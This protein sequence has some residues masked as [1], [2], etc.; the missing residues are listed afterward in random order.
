MQMISVSSAVKNHIMQTQLTDL[1]KSAEKVSL[2]INM[3][4]AEY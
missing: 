3:Q 2:K 1:A 4:I